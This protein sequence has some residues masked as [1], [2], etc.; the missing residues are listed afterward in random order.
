M[1]LLDDSPETAKDEKGF[2]RV[3]KLERTKQDLTR[4][5]YHNAISSRS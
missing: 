4:H 2:I 3:I 5:D 1:R